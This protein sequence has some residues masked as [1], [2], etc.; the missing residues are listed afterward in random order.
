[1]NPKEQ[2]EQI[3]LAETFLRELSRGLPQD[4]RIMAGYAGEATVQTDAHGKK[5]NGGWWPVPWRDGKFIDPNA[6]CYVCISSSIKTPNP[7]NGTMRY[8]RGEASFGHGLALMVDDIGTGKGSKGGL[9]VES[10]VKVLAPT[11]VVETSPENFQVWYFLDKP[12]PSMA[13]FK[14]FIR[15]F[16]DAVLKKGGDNTIK[17]VSRYGRMPCGIN[18]KRVSPDGP[19]KYPVAGGDGGTGGTFRVRLRYFRPLHRY[20]PEEIASAFKYQIVMPVKRQFDVDPEDL[21]IDH[22]WL[23]MAEDILSKAG[24]G[25]GSGGAVSMNMSGKFRIQC[26]WGSEH[27]NG[28]P[29]GA[30]FRGPIPGAEVEFVFGCGHD[31]CRKDNNRTWHAF[32]DEIVMPQIIEELE[33][34]NRAFA[35]Q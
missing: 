27:H 32:I 14:A 21:A 7:K 16:V 11:A 35:A 1:M 31:T 29:F 6:N 23:R 4:E 22:V 28:D 10:L 13:H 5:V 34:A 25:E 2:I 15:G 24:M 17:D 12:D 33:E 19:Y 3:E 9:T 26:P 20:S 30:Y 18:N 8:W